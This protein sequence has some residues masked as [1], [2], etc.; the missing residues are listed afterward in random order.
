[1]AL[2]EIFGKFWKNIQIGIQI[3]YLNDD[4]IPASSRKE[5]IRQQHRQHGLLAIPNDYKEFP[6]NK[7]R[8]HHCHYRY[9]CSVSIVFVVIVFGIIVIVS[10]ST[11]YYVD[12]FTALENPS[13]W[14]MT[15]QSCRLIVPI[16]NKNARHT[17]SRSSSDCYLFS[18]VNHYHDRLRRNMV[19]MHSISSMQYNTIRLASSIMNENDN[20]ANSNMTSTSSTTTTSSGNWFKRIQQLYITDNKNNDEKKLSTKEKLAKMGIAAVLSYGWVSNMSYSVTVSMAWYIFSK[21]VSFIYIYFF[22]STCLL[23]DISKNL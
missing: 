23:K 19:D 2:L 8:L 16:Y 1:M 12:A 17:I 7:Q 14:L 18:K 4:N 9:Y 13:S 6:R 15:K 21:R 3:R 11:P 10:P 5:M 20:T 22:F